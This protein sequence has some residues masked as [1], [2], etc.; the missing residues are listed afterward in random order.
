MINELRSITNTGRVVPWRVQVDESVQDQHVP[1]AFSTNDESF[2][3]HTA[4]AGN[5]IGQFAG[6]TVVSHIRSGR[7]VPLLPDYRSEVY[8]LHLYY[9]SRMAQPE[10][11]RRFIELAVERLSNS[12]SL[13][14][15]TEELWLA[16]HKGI[17]DLR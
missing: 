12:K 4:L 3:L 10:R 15:D 1:P 6:P 13:I 11:V 8:S 14:L 9:G 16:H 5:I 17:A 7:L 2:E